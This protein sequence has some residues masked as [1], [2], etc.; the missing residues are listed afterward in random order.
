MCDIIE[1]VKRLIEVKLDQQI[2]NDFAIGEY[3]KKFPGVKPQGFHY[4]DGFEILSETKIR[5]NFIWGMGDHEY[6]DF[7]DV[8]LTP[9]QRD[10]KINQIVNT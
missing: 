6:N 4:Y 10:G 9:E 7:F 3:N 5:V 8:D 1:S 2:V